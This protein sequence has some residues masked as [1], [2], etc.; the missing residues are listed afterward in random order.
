MSV[1]MGGGG[2]GLEYK[3]TLKTNFIPT[4]VFVGSKQYY[5]VLEA[6][7]FFSQKNII[8]FY[9][10]LYFYFGRFQLGPPA[11]P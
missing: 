10:Q 7:L 1:T 4:N 2:G 8:F 6:I 9:K 3:Q 5:I 11:I